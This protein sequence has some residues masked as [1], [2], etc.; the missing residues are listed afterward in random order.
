MSHHWSFPTASCQKSSFTAN[1][2]VKFIKGLVLLMEN[3]R[4]VCV[5]QYKQKPC[6]RS[7]RWWLQWLYC[8]GNVQLPMLQFHR[9]GVPLSSVSPSQIQPLEGAATKTPLA[10][11]TGIIAGPPARDSIGGGASGSHQ[12]RGRCPRV[13]R[14]CVRLTSVKVSDG[15]LRC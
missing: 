8:Y 1:L 12:G 3:L 13:C 7:R 6:A 9:C 4:L 11:N 14:P 10:A 15:M 2:P 5:D